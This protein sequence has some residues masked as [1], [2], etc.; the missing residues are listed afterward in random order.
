MVISQKM[1]GAINEQIKH[2]FFSYWLYLSMAFSLEAQD[3]KVFAKWFYAQA[4]EE[5]DHAMKMANYLFNQGAEVKLLAL[6]Q[7]KNNFD[8][9]LE[10]C[11]E[12]VTHEEWITKKIN[13]L[14]ALAR[15]ENDFATENFMQWFI[16][17]QVEEVA[18]ANELVGLV[19]MAN[20]PGQMLMVEQRIMALRV[21]G[22]EA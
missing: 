7:P 22:S 4:D 14:V 3:L 19:K 8:S 1:A 5:K 13:E 16:M 21:E 12:S 10:I 15:S 2:E 17:E 11:E 6:E 20:N 9:V 18:K